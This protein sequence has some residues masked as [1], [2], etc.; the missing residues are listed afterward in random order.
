MGVPGPPYTEPGGQLTNTA[1]Q[2]GDRVLAFS[3]DFLTAHIEASLRRPG[4]YGYVI[5]GAQVLEYIGADCEMTLQAYRE[6][7]SPRP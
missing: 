4:F 3:S 7:P 6:R 1:R 5:R 2:L